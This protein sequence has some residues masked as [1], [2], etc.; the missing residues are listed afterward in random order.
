MTD[1]WRQP[2]EE[3]AT[4]ATIAGPAA[5]PLSLAEVKLHCR[6]TTSDD[7][8]YLRGLMVAA[9]RRAELVTRRV[10]ATQTI[11]MTLDYFPAEVVIE[12]A[13]VHSVTSLQY[14]D[15]AGDLTTLDSD[16]YQTDLE[17]TPARVCPAW[18]SVWPS[19]RG[20][21]RS[22]RLTF[23]AGYCPQLTASAAANTFTSAG[24]AFVDGERVRL[25]NEGGALPTGV[26]DETDYF[27][28]SASGQAFSVATT[29]GGS[30]VDLT[31]AGTG[32]HFAD[33]L[34]E[35]LKVAVLLMVGHWYA[36]REAVVT[37]TIAAALPMTVD[38]LLDCERWGSYP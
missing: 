18:G 1:Y 35:S 10:L 38:A 2:M 31:S 27:V 30:A 16:E 21:Y 29:P 23:V 15:D 36:N 14:L 8:A 3:V 7:D 33:D 19:T 12:R 20:D 26:S 11:R 4:Y 24:K 6:V 5:E 9:R 25:R 32:T 13:P 37:G 17:A 22:V 28:V 34:P